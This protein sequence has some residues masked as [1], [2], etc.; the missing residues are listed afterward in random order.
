MHP[1]KKCGERWRKLFNQLNFGDYSNLP[2]TYVF[3]QVVFP[4]KLSVA[5]LTPSTSCPMQSSHMPIQI[6]QSCKSTVA[7][8]TGKHDCQM[9]RYPNSPD[10]YLHSC[11]CR[12]LPYWWRE[13]WHHTLPWC[14]V[15]KTCLWLAAILQHVQRSQ[16]T[17]ESDWLSN[18]W[19]H[20]LPWCHLQLT[21][22]LICIL[23]LIGQKSN[24]VTCCHGVMCSGGSIYA[25]DVGIILILYNIHNDSRRVSATSKA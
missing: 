6:V 3:P 12:E 14:H 10:L 16:S 5:P 9:T 24:D 22:H 8:F 4:V 25:A 18:W 21:C 20:W 13:W 1:R 19:C 11:T 17:L 23:F 15:Q 2:S 7:V